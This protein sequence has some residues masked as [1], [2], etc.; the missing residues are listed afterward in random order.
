M[1]SVIWRKLTAVILVLFILG[2]F[3]ASVM[4]TSKGIEFTSFEIR[5][6]GWNSINGFLIFIAT[7]ISIA[8]FLAALSFNYGGRKLKLVFLVFWATSTIA[9]LLIGIITLAVGTITYDANQAGCTSD[10][11]GLAGIFKQIDTIYE[12]ANDLL[13]SADCPCIFLN[14]PT[15]AGYPETKEEQAFWTNISSNS[16]TKISK[17][18]TVSLDSMW[19]ALIEKDSTF[20]DF[21]RST[22]Y[23]F[24]D[25]IEAQFNC[26]GWCHR[27]YTKEVKIGTLS[28]TTKT[29][30]LMRYLFTE[31]DRLPVAPHK[32]HG[33]MKDTFEYLNPIFVA[34]GSLLL[35]MFA[36]M[37]PVFVLGLSNYG[38]EE[39]DQ[40]SQDG[41]Q[42][43]MDDKSEKNDA[44]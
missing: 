11:H 16:A 37:V 41:I 17:C 30:K 5:S 13:C 28:V 9:T 23:D 31:A 18:P 14:Q 33:C 22:F 15:Y 12:H 32:N 19:K 39:E 4:L 35:C 10:S 42:I 43:E 34:I 40:D 26:T 29:R 8:I 7:F 2:L 44:Q 36:L 25:K 1:C 38:K 20:N 21:N 6:S 24:F 3:I 27:S